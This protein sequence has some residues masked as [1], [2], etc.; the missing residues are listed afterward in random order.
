MKVRRIGSDLFI[1][2]DDGIIVLAMFIAGRQI[3]C[4]K[5]DNRPIWWIKHEKKRKYENN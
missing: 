4:R 5:K 1:G 3:I 2:S